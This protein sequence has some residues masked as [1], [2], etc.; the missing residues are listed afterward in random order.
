MLTQ[1]NWL[2]LGCIVLIFFSTLLSGYKGLVKELSSLANWVVSIWF[3]F[4]F[5]QPVASYLFE[6]IQPELLRYAIGFF[7]VFGLILLIG[8]LLNKLISW[9]ISATGLKGP[10]RLL[11]LLFGAV[12]GVLF[13]TLLML[14]AEN[15]A[16]TRIE[17]WQT[18]VLLP[19]FEPFGHWLYNFLPHEVE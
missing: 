11:G 3:G 12:R 4:V 2:D 19:Y 6:G 14:A 16:F 8:T 7:I 18:S 1:F 15:T 10:D 13:I 17:A 5:Y 9:L